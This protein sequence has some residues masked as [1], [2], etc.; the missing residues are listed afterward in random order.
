MG[1]RDARFLLEGIQ[2]AYWVGQTAALELSIPASY[3]VE[4]DIEADLAAGLTPALGRLLQRHPM[5]RAVILSSGEQHVL[6]EVGSY[7]VQILDLR[8]L[9]APRREERREALRA[10]MRARELP[11]N[12]WPQFD[13]RATRNEAGLRLHLRFALWM[14]DGW[15][16]HLL[17]Q[18]LLTL[19]AD[20]AASLPPLAMSFAD[21][22]EAQRQ[23]RQGPQWRK[24]WD[25]WQPRL[26]HFPGP[27]ALPLTRRLGGGERPRFRHI[28]SRLAAEEWARVVGVCAK[29]RLT[30][31]LLACAV[32]TEVLARYAGSSHFA[33]TVL[34]SGRFK[35]LPRAS[36]V[37]GNFGTTILLEVDA[38]RERTFLERA[39][40][41]Q[42]QF[43][44]DA[45]RIEVSGID[46]TR[47][48][49]QRAQTGP[50][51]SVPVTFTAVT[52]PATADD[53]RRP[54]ARIDHAS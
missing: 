36:G 41:L 3:Y 46:V 4:A 33:I 34:Y 54:K 18:E 16:F 9:T 47:A 15:S 10:E 52:P 53:R 50:G 21:Y 1:H 26:P 29:F 7:E 49:Q 37:F 5:L 35:H 24:A 27:P 11:P 38:S 12:V 14:M 45:E 30:P 13:I 20:P 39:R 8:N 42:R 23:V 40:S 17:L 22:V 19:S 32:Y 28:S 48:L 25:Y 51:V 44:R 43:W 31:S 2:Q 6:D